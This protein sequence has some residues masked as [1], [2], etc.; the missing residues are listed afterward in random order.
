ME[1]EPFHGESFTLLQHRRHLLD[2]VG[3]ALQPGTPE[4]AVARVEGQRGGHGCMICHTGIV[5][6]GAPAAIIAVG[7]G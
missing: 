6:K 5:L 1:V 4:R 2:G 7:C 3:I